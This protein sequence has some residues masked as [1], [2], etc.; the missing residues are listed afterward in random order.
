MLI[1]LDSKKE[2]ILFLSC[3]KNSIWKK[4]KNE[5]ANGTHESLPTALELTEWYILSYNIIYNVY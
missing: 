5:K 2:Q 1:R 3:A 4:V